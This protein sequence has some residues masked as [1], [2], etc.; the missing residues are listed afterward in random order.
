MGGSPD[1]PPPPPPDP[2]GGKKWSQ[3]EPVER[4]Y[5][6]EKTLDRFQEYKEL[7]NEAETKVLQTLFV[8]NTG[9]VAAVVGRLAS[10]DLSNDLLVSLFC[11]AAGVFS[12]LLRAAWAYYRADYKLTVAYKR[13]LEGF[14]N[15]ELGILTLLASG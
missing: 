11:S 15:N 12:L 9:G 13:D 3:M 6:L 4:S 1:Q 2:K 7:K 10:A 14:Y 8:L 5:H